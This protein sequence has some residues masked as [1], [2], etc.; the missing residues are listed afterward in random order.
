VTDFD[1]L[2]GE[3]GKDRA[4]IFLS[5]EIPP[6][7][8]KGSR[9]K[10]PWFKIWIKPRE[11][12]REI[13]E[14]DAGYLVLPLAIITGF[15]YTLDRVMSRNLG[16]SYSLTAVIVIALIGGPIGGLVS[17]YLLGALSSWLGKK[18]G[19][20]GEVGEVQAAVA[21]SSIPWILLIFLAILQ[22]ALFGTEV[23]SSYTPK[24]DVLRNSNLVNFVLTGLYLLGLETTGTVLLF[25]RLA[26]LVK[27]VAEAHRFSAWRSLLT[28]LIPYLV[29]LIGVLIC[30]VSL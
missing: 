24:F 3:S 27:C 20:E 5:G 12:M 21:W 10:H 23:F 29:L 18:M 11:T 16:D 6:E 30:V 22:I 15:G 7:E 4:D 25:W 8:E 26:L 17:V 1:D 9:P 13:I 28:I 19:G 2:I 14:F